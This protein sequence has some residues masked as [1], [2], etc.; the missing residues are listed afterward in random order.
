MLR[1]HLGPHEELKPL[2]AAL[3]RLTLPILA[4]A[5]AVD[6]LSN[7]VKTSEQE[8]ER[9]RE[10][11]RHTSS[12]A[13]TRTH[14]HTQRH[15]HTQHTHTQHTHTR[16]RARTNTIHRICLSDCNRS[17]YFPMSLYVLD[18]TETTF[19]GSHTS[20]ISE[21]V[22]PL[23]E[24]QVITCYLGGT[25]TNSSKVALVHSSPLKSSAPQASNLCI[26]KPETR[27]TYRP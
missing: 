13:R 27:T 21:I 2:S 8:R 6:S 12:L 16:V 22:F 10:R 4:A 26:I 20:N 5:R 3:L 24:Q 25:R 7:N 1:K 17:I 18:H 14:T 19:F 11:V 23:S 15:T 9:E